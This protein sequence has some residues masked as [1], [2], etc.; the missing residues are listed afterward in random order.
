MIFLVFYFI[1]GIPDSPSN[2]IIHTDTFTSSSVN[3]SWTESSSPCVTEYRYTVSSTTI[4]STTTSN[5]AVLEGLVPSDD[6]YCVTVAAVD[7]ANRTNSIIVI[8]FVSFLMVRIVS[9]SDNEKFLHNCLFCF[10]IYSL[11]L[12]L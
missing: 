10:V 11:S 6:P 7:T 3:I 5:S 2:V 9:S 1:I 4:N 8:L 12:F